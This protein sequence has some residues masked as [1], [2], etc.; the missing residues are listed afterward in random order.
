MENSPPKTYDEFVTRFPGMAAGWE[1]LGK[2]SREDGPL[3]PK[4]VALV[5]LGIAI[6]SGL[7]GPVHSA[8]RKAVAAGATRKEME[9]VILLT[10]STLGMPRCVSAWTW[11]RDVIG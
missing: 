5:K 7:E 3:G 11:M 8:V 10:A 4:T 9:Q 1:Q 2:A 6:G